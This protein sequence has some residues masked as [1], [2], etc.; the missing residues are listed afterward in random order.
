VTPVEPVTG[1]CANTGHAVTINS[2]VLNDR[3][4]RFISEWWS[5]L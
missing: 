2:E 4:V 1:V 5:A 3:G